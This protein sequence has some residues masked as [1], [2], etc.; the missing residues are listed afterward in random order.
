MTTTES[1]KRRQQHQHQQRT[2]AQRQ[3]GQ[4]ESTR[5]MSSNNIQATITHEMVEQYQNLHQMLGSPVYI[6]KVGFNYVL[7]YA[8]GSTKEITFQPP[9]PPPPLSHQPLFQQGV[10]PPPPPPTA[11]TFASPTP[12]PTNMAPTPTIR[13]NAAAAFPPPPLFNPNPVRHTTATQRNPRNLFASLAN[14]G[15]CV[16][17]LLYLLTAPGY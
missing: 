9:P 12:T 16:F 14:Q 5:T 11:F 2:T 1:K 8:N 7:H 10:P 13:N 15:M 3:Q 6:Q 4:H 17:K